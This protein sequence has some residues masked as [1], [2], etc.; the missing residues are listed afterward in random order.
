MSTSVGTPPTVSMGLHSVFGTQSVLSAQ[1]GAGRGLPCSLH[2][3]ATTQREVSKD[4]RRTGAS[5]AMNR[6]MDTWLSSMSKQPN[7]EA[8]RD[9]LREGAPSTRT[10]GR[11]SVTS[12]R[13]WTQ[14]RPHDEITGLEDAFERHKASFDLDGDG[15]MGVQELIVILDRCQLY[16]GVFTPKKVRDYFKTLH[17]STG[18]HAVKF[19]EF[20]NAIRWA[21]DMRRLDLDTVVRRVIILSKRLCDREACVQ[22]RLE[23]VFDSFCTKNPTYMSAFEFGGLC[24]K[25]ALPLCMGDIFL[26][27]SHVPGGVEGKGVDFHGFFGLVTKVGEQ[28]QMGEEIYA[29]F[30]KAVETL[31]TDMTVIT[32][33]KVRLRVAAATVTGANWQNFFNETDKD[34][35]Q[36]IDWDEFLQMCRTKLHMVDKE[37]HVRILFENID[38]DGSDSVSLNEIVAF[39][40]SD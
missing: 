4:L 24:R 16:D 26:L 15:S 32:R 1:P 9:L 7:G 34:G 5:I 23:V 22:K 36:C 10:R 28:L 3:L 40:S 37:S 18:V 6:S 8:E 27:F 33:L 35:S 39:I 29:I 38:R 11:L 12:E 20:K 14:S 17:V 13:Q 31:E 2:S 30:A 19:V 21:A 25:V